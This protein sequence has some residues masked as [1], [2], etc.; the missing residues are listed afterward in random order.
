MQTS[1]VVQDK[2]LSPNWT[3]RHSPIIT[4]NMNRTPMRSNRSTQQIMP[5]QENGQHLTYTKLYRDIKMW[6]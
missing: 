6:D 2:F 3:A 5:I 4:E 1:V